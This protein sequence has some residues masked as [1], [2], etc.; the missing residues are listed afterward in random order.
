MPLRVSLILIEMDAPAAALE[1]DDPLV[2]GAVGAN[3]VR[4][5]IA[6]SKPMPLITKN[7][8]ESEGVMPAGYASERTSRAVEARSAVRYGGSQLHQIH[9][10]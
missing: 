6:V 4:D 5:W 2:G 7:W 10:I 1:E 8:L 9:V 3:V